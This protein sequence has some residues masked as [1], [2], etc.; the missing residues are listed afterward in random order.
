LTPLGFAHR[1]VPVDKEVGFDDRAPVDKAAASAILGAMTM[2]DGNT[3]PKTQSDTR[4]EF[5][6]DERRRPR[7]ITMWDF[8]WLER[9]WPGGGYEDWDQA[10][11]ELVER[12]Y[13]AVRI[14]AYPH[15]IAA[16]TWA[17]PAGTAD[18][19]TETESGAAEAENG[20]EA[21][22]HRGRS[23]PEWELIPVWSVNG[24]GAPM[25]CRVQVLPALLDF[26]EACAK[27]DIMV[28]LSSWFRRDTS[29][30][31]RLLSSPQRHADAWIATLSALGDAGLLDHILYVDLCNEWP[32]RIWAPFF[33]GQD[34]DAEAADGG[35]Q[36]NW[37]S[38]HSLDWLKRAATRIRAAYPELPLTVSV[39]PW[40]D[41]RADRLDFV[42]FYEPHLWMSGGEFYHRVGYT[43]QHFFDNSEYELVQRHAR[44]LYYNDKEKWDGVLTGMIDDAAATAREQQKPLMT[45]ECWAIT[46]YKDGPM[47][48]WDWVKE[49]NAIGT[50]R[51]AESGAWAAIATSNFCGP[52]FVGMWRD[53]AWHREL[54]DTIRK[55]VLS[56][57]TPE[58]LAQRL[59]A[60]TE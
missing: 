34:I 50:R 49:L 31:W 48:P 54:T 5:R 44:R 14:D 15:L 42:D 2:N 41:K 29:E 26:V 52:Q 55:S 59:P 8:S 27:R 33:S 24:W 4:P 51:A 11:D 3:D 36:A 56:V 58:L 7:A 39:M 9:R 46:D 32:T 60:A 43:F 53:V 22:L 1:R 25:R 40:Q 23:E 12:G 20:P 57:P 18:N 17:G 38:D 30:A 21:T 19:T 13:D 47:L 6:G 35:G 45:T 37:Y 16:G 28:G 10:L